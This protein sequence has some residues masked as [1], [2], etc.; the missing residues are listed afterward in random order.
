MKHLILVNHLGEEA[1]RHPLFVEGEDFVREEPTPICVWV[2]KILVV[3][4]E[5][6]D[7][8]KA[9]L[10]EKQVEEAEEPEV[11]EKAEEIQE[12]V[13][14]EDR[15]DEDAGKDEEIPTELEEPREVCQGCKEVVVVSELTDDGICKRCDEA[16]KAQEKEAK[17]PLPETP[18][19]P[20]K[21]RHKTRRK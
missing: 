13:R 19:A 1:V 5:K 3:D 8:A 11:E 6:Y 17:E 18:L 15:V 20:L 9:E 16:K 7:E 10:A 14:L 21:P 4:P 12:D 2:S